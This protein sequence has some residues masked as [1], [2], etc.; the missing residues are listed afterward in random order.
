M[1]ADFCY[2]VPLPGEGDS[3]IFLCGFDTAHEVELPGVSKP[4]SAFPTLSAAVRM[5]EPLINNTR[6]APDLELDNLA[7]LAGLRNPASMLYIP[8]AN[9]DLNWGGLLFLTTRNDRA[10]TTQDTTFGQGISQPVLELLKGIE[11]KSSSEEEHTST[12]QKEYLDLEAAFQQ[13]LLQLSELEQ[14]T[15][16]V[17]LEVPDDVIAYGEDQAV[18]Q[19]L[20]LA[21]AEMGHMQDQLTEARQKL[22]SMEALGP[23][24]TSASQVNQEVFARDTRKI[25][26]TLDSL[27]GKADLLITGSAGELTPVQLKFINQV[28]ND[29][30]RIQLLLEDLFSSGKQGGL[31]AFDLVEVIDLAMAE[32][33]SDFQAKNCSLHLS[34]DEAI[35]LISGSPETFKRIL[36]QLVHNAVMASQPGGAV[37]LDVRLNPADEQQTLLV[38]VTDSG[39]GILPEDLEKVFS[40][41]ENGEEIQISGLGDSPGDLQV[42]HS[43]VESLGGSISAHSAKGEGTTFVGSIPIV[44][45]G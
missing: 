10:W 21:L 9:A 38:K 26:D 36:S 40:E 7:D 33:R 45:A 27:K 8:L 16:A 25:Q 12:L 17:Q 20:Q 24:N 42:T 30:D 5:A 19:E 44:F 28:K 34:I 15:G 39:A 32:I 2:L 37:Q 35:P 41:P 13:V 11:K 29:T 6:T 22:A 1:L 18:G 4:Q 31:S 23:D 3:L 14:E 43:L